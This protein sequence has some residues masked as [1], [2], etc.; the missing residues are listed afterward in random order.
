[1]YSQGMFNSL[2][3]YKYSTQLLSVF[4]RFM[5]FKLK[6]NESVMDKL[7][8]I[9]QIVFGILKKYVQKK[10]YENGPSHSQNDSECTTFLHICEK[11]DFCIKGCLGYY[12][13]I[14]SVQCFY[15]TTCGEHINM[16]DGCTDDKI[17]QIHLY[18]SMINAIP[19]P[20]KL[21]LCGNG[22]VSTKDQYCDNGN[23]LPNDGYYKYKV[24]CPEGCYICKGWY[25]YYK[26]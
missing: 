20:A 17:Y 4:W 25:L 15:R 23:Y 6:N 24:Q 7:T 19:Q 9:I 10:I 18:G 1:M 8:Q 22:I 11:G 26:M 2:I 13:A 3:N 5:G 14:E 16:I 21:L 12:Y